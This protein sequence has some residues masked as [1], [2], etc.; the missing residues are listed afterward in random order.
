[1]CTLW[2]FSNATLLYGLLF[3]KISNYWSNKSWPGLLF[4]VL[5]TRV[6]KRFKQTNLCLD[7]LHNT[8]PTRIHVRFANDM[9]S[10]SI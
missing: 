4:K 5:M 10:Q 9:Y 3:D 2:L 7:Y 6:I 1:M 8:Y